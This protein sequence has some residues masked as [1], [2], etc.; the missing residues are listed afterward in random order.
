MTAHKHASKAESTQLLVAG[1][2]PV[3]LFGALCA[4]RGGLDVMVLEQNFRGYGYGYATVLHPLT[5]DLL[6]E[7]GLSDTVRCAGNTVDHIQLSVDRAEVR[8]LDLA[9]PALTVAQSALEELLLKE[10][11]REGAEIRSP[12]RATALEQDGNL[13]R[14]QIERRELTTIGSPAQYTEWQPVE[15]G[16]IEAAFVI[17]A[18]GYD[19][20][21]REVLGIETVNVGA[22]E[23][24]AMFEGS[25]GDFAEF[26]LGFT[27]DLSS[28]VVPLA[29]RRARWGFQLGSD[30]TLTPDLEHLRRLLAERGSTHVALPDRVDW[31]TV[32]HFERRLA[33]SFGHGRVWLAGDAAHITSPFGGQSMNGG[34]LEARDLVVGIAACISGAKPLSSLEHL[35]ME[36]Q[37]EWGRLLGVNTRFETS[38]D[39]PQWVLS[40]ARQIV[41]ALPASRRDLQELLAQLGLVVY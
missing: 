14:V 21:V 25:G 37:R 2:G 23:T 8:C 26:E 11:R 29:D 20:R 38:P 4:A 36:R 24:F 22:T 33:T 13:V 30:F 16:E 10:L 19:S 27:S 39:A 35:G 12:C 41:S 31:S 17:G 1:G 40:L 5:V 15:T 32:T 28:V 9:R 7:V 6:A 18:D 3:G 34:L